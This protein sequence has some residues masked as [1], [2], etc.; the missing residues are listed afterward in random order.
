MLN[1]ASTAILLCA[2]DE[3]VAKL[4]EETGHPERLATLVIE[5]SNKKSVEAAAAALARD[6]RGKL[7]GLINNAGVRLGWGKGRARVKAGNGQLEPRSG[8]SVR[9]SSTGGC[10]DEAVTRYDWQS[11]G[12][13]TI[14]CAAAASERAAECVLCVRQSSHQICVCTAHSPSICTSV[15]PPICRSRH[16]TVQF[17]LHTRASCCRYVPRLRQGS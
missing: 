13:I 6:F 3:A 10:Q 7:G 15:C 14:G 8:P 17:R 2:A 4:G 5:V 11:N 9:V 16:T 1:Q 12:S